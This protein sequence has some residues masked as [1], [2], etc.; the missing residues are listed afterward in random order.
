MT[1]GNAQSPFFHEERH[2]SLEAI[3][4]TPITICGAGSLGGPITETLARMGYTCLT[5]V[6][7][8]RIEVRNLS[9][10]PYIRAEIG[11]F[12]A[13]ALTGD[14]YRA[15]HAKVEGIVGELTEKNAIPLLSG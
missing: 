6:D 5:V 7:R 3:R 4:H 10:Q 11:T 14:L 2:Q 12:K 1:T 9:T 13:R 8:D 15:V